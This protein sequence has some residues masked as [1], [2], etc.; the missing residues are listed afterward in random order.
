MEWE[1]TT[2]NVG[3]NSPANGAE[4]HLVLAQGSL[5]GRADLSQIGTKTH[6][7][8]HAGAQQPCELAS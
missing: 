4:H 6:S 8:H 7:C 2:E 3:D 5:R 1:C